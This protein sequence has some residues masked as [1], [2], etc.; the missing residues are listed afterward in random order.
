MT[1]AAGGPCSSSTLL[2]TQAVDSAVSAG[3]WGFESSF[4][5]EYIGVGAFGKRTMALERKCQ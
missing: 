2:R 4:L 5:K 3:G 1:G